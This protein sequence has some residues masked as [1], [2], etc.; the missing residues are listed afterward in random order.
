MAFFLLVLTEHHLQYLLED[1]FDAQTKWRFIGLCL[2]LT[3]SML[4]AI[5]SNNPSS[6]EQY[7]E[8]L[9]RWINGGR[10]TVKRLIDAL[11]A[12][13]VQMNGIA[14]RLQEKYAERA[15]PEEGRPY[16]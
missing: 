10:A 5:K 11:E 16:D 1:T 4:S 2:G 6:E 15:T 3:N 13:T 8:M 7:T 14:E 9:S 12:K